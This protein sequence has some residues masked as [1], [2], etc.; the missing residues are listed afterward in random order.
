M[1][2]DRFWA[3][4]IAVWGIM[5]FSW[6]S[7]SEP[8]N[9]ARA[10]MTAPTMPRQPITPIGDVERRSGLYNAPETPPTTI[11]TIAGCDDVVAL[12]YS[13]GW[14]ATE[15]DTLRR[16]ARAESA[17]MAW[18]HN[19]KDPH[20]GSYGI[21]QING[22]WCTPNSNWPIG[23]LQTHGL[24]NSCD[25]LYSATANLQAALAIWQNSG[26]GVWATY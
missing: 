17:C 15:L 12:A 8:L 24:V 19:P 13:L 7:S 20:T 6:A 9:V 3:V 21:M 11:T 4:F 22:F 14:P 1:F 25:D 18:A 26:W 5:A 2:L 23:W 10:P 16:V